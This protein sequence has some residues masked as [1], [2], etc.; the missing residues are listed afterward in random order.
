MTKAKAQRPRQLCP[1]C[2]ICS[3]KKQGKST[4]QDFHCI[5]MHVILRS[6][7]TKNLF[8]KNSSGT[9][10]MLRFAHIIPTPYLRSGQVCPRS[11]VPPE[12]HRDDVRHGAGGP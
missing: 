8:F 1:P 12:G 6:E 4:A 7:A 3:H 2:Y 10:V 11:P 9:S 5:N